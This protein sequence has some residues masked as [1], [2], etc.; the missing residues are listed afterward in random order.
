MAP[1]AG[2]PDG[3]SDYQALTTL[4]IWV[5]H[6][7]D[8]EVVDYYKSL[9]AVRRIEQLT[10]QK[11]HR[12]STIAE[13]DYRNHDHIFT[14]GENKAYHHDAWTEMYNEE[15]FYKWLLRFRKE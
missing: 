1:I 9:R 13:A 10:S 5:A 12:T 4:P 2:G 6:N 3:V 14:S 11:F 7:I 8:D 15:N